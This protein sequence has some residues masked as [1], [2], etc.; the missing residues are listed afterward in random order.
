MKFLNDLS[1]AVLYLGFMNNISWM[2][3]DKVDNFDDWW[4][5]KFTTLTLYT[6][7]I[8]VHKLD[9]IAKK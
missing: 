7:A 5:Y 4:Y 6:A 8:F 3:A 1:G 9:E 2:N